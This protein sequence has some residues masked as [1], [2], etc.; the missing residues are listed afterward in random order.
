[1]ENP[2]FTWLFIK[3][4]ISVTLIIFLAFILVKYL[5]PRTRL[6]KRRSSRFFEVLDHLS[7]ESNKRIYLI[8]GGS[9]H[10]VVGAS[11]RSLSTLGEVSAEEVKGVL[12]GHD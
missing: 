10:W 4:I 1:M 11:D 12:G 5:L 9:K 7:L 3:M 2:D 6:G 8:R